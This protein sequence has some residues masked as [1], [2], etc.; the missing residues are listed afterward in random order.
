LG[1]IKRE[2][3]RND[4]GEADPGDILGKFEALCDCC[5]GSG[6]IPLDPKDIPENKPDYVAALAD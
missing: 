3:R 6:E 1:R 2:P 4:A 5:N